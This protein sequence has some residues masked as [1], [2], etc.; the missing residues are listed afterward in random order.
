LKIDR[1]GKKR[2]L[3]NEALKKEEQPKKKGKAE[4]KI[5][6]LVPVKQ[7]VI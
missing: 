3:Q 4:D 7:E 2:K 6:E 1:K 5:P